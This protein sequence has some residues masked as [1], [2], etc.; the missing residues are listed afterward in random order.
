MD[1]IQLS[2]KPVVL[3]L[4]DGSYTCTSCGPPYTIKADGS[5]QVV[6]GHP[7]TESVQVVSDHAIKVTDKAAGKQVA[8]ETD[9]V[10]ADGKSYTAEWVDYSG[11]APSTIKETYTRISDGAPGSHAI[12]GSWKETKILSLDGADFATSFA[13]TDDGFTMTSNGQSYE[14]KFDGKKVSLKGDPLHTDVTVKKV[15]ADEVVETDTRKG[16]VVQ[17]LTYKVSADGK[18]I[19]VTSTVLPANRTAHWTMDKTS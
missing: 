18:T 5:D 2:K 17:V 7:I 19:H 13:M 14:A 15:A 10:A 6:K 4:A 11:T 3:L 8:V 12:S 16:K 9:T 1:H